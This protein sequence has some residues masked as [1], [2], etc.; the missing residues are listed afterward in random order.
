MIRLCWMAMIDSNYMYYLQRNE[1]TYST[2]NSYLFYI[3]IKG[4]YL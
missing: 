3:S 2:S 4:N 1:Q